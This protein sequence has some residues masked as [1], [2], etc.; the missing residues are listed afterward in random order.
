MKCLFTGC[1][2]KNLSAVLPGVHEMP[3]YRMSRKQLHMAAP[4]A[5]SSIKGL[6]ER[7]S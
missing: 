7:G 6:S 4:Q 5:A 3:F 1:P 2:G